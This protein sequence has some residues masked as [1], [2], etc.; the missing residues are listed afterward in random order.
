M[1]HISATAVQNAHG[2]E[3]LTGSQEVRQQ[4]E[5]TAT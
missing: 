5:P 4:P 3:M 2:K 1:E